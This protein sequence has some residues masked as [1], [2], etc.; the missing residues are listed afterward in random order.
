MA[1]A[2]END[3]NLYAYG[4]I[5]DKKLDQAITEFKTI[6]DKFPNSWNAHDSLGE[7]LA[8]KGDKAGAIASYGKALSMVKD[9]KQKK[10]IEGVLKQ[11]KN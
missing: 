4:L 2:T 5:A 11:L 3:L 7:A 10:R 1:I 9:D 6:V 8:M